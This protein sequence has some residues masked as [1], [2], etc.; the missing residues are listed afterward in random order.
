M[1]Y[2]SSHSSWNYSHVDLWALLG[3]AQMEIVSLK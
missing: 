1:A 3:E 2:A